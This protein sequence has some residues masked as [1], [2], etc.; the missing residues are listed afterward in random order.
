MLPKDLIEQ[1]HAM[2]PE[3]PIEHLRTILPF[4]L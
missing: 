1:P 4:N 2:L 3:D